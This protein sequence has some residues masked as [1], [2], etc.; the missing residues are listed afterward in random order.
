METRGNRQT[1]SQNA[2]LY[3]YIMLQWGSDAKVRSHTH[4][5]VNND[6]LTQT[7]IHSCKPV[8][9]VETFTISFTPSCL[10]SWSCINEYHA[11]D[12]GGY[13]NIHYSRSNCSVIQS[14]PEKLSWRWNEQVYQGVKRFERSYALDIVLLKKVPFTLLGFTSINP[15]NPI[16]VF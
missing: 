5:Y 12:N 14:F 4:S 3:R 1:D 10:S 13:V 7:M 8:F 16:N 15:I 11:I 9:S 6:A 2:L